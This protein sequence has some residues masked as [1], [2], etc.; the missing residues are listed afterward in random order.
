MTE[1]RKDKIERRK[2]KSRRGSRKKE[3]RRKICEGREEMN[4]CVHE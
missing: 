3:A 2:E 4:E 1:V